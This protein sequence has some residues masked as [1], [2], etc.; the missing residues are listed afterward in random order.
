[1]TRIALFVAFLMSFAAPMVAQCGTP[2][3]PSETFRLC[4]QIEEG[5]PLG[6]LAILTGDMSVNA[7]EAVFAN[8]TD[9][10]G[11]EG[12]L[13]AATGLSMVYVT[14]DWCKSCRVIKRHALAD[15]DVQAALAS[16]V[17]IS[18]GVSDFGRALQALLDE[19]GSVGPPTM[20]FLDSERREVP[21]TRLL[22]EVG[23]VDMLGS[24]AGVSR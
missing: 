6:P 8:I 5:D 7:P 14:A 1:M 2:L 10:A 12:A 16:L 19:L 3:H 13:D 15:A 4:A 18:V 22:G 21:G 11:L 23:P 17:P 20:V 24:L 9:G